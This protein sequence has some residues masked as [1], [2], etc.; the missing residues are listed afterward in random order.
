MSRLPL[1]KVALEELTIVSYHRVECEITTLDHQRI[2][3]QFVDR[4]LTVFSSAE[5]LELGM[6]IG[7][8][9]GFGRLLVAAGICEHSNQVFASGDFREERR[10]ALA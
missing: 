10:D 2:D 9:M 3:Q 5:I 1:V 7:Q 4:L 8:Y 6:M